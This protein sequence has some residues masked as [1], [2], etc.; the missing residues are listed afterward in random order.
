[1]LD[2][3]YLKKRME[4]MALRKNLTLSASRPPTRSDLRRLINLLHPADVGI[5]LVRIG[6]SADGGYLVPDDLRGITACFSP[7]VDTN[8]S[9][10]SSLSQ[11]GLHCH[12]ADASVEAPPISI[13]RSTFEQ[14]YLQSYASDRTIT[15]DEWVNRHD[16]S[17][18]DLIL[19]MDIEGS[20]YE[21]LSAASDETI[22]RFRLIVLELHN[23]DY[24]A[25]KLFY[26]FVLSTIARL[27][28]SHTVVHLH[29]N[30]CT[31][32]IL[33]RDLEIPPTL[34]LTMLRKDRHATACA[35][36]QLPH[37]L[38]ADNVSGNPS[39]TLPTYWWR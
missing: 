10:E 31:A 38:D 19:Q 1:M 15:L 35:V 22:S 12:L 28:K 23:L 16:A 20:E 13:P 36:R 7:G 2:L 25:N 27:C 30:N 5:P 3:Y 34:E 33:I 24:I 4:R 29:P 37:D 17:G 14:K 39:V 11:M 18:E 26:T 6:S 9:F 8:S 21:V 32:P